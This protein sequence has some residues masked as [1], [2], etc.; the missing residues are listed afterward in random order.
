MRTL[1][2][3]YRI[4]HS[5]FKQLEKPAYFDPKSIKPGYDLRSESGRSVHIEN[6]F[7]GRARSGDYVLVAP[8]GA[9]VSHRE[10]GDLELPQGNFRVQQV[11]DTHPEEV[12]SR[13]HR[14]AGEFASPMRRQELD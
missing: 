4:G 2:N 5:V 10:H 12:R 11:R 14:I 8:A 1:A 6:V 13:T 3:F 7:R 9:T